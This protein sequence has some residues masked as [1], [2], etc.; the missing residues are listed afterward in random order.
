MKRRSVFE[1]VADAV[2]WGMG[3]PA[4]IAAWVLVVLV[5]FVLGALDQGLFT[6]GHSFLP[7]WF[8]S[9]GWNFPLNTVT[10]LAELYIGFLVG[11]AANRTE[12]ANA[13]LAAAQAITIDH[14]LRETNELD[15]LLRE[16]TELTR[17]LHARLVQVS[18][19]LGI[20]EDGDDH[21]AGGG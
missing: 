19:H 13:G 2:S 14:I 7:A 6:G 20:E 4:N 9:T 3:T 17:L 16:N 10:T 15:E 18:A 1:R 5:W 12:R 8:T 11:A 21:G